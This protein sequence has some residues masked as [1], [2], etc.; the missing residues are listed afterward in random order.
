L[1]TSTAISNQLNDQDQEASKGYAS[2]Q[3]QKIGWLLKPSSA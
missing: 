3:G 1:S 2:A